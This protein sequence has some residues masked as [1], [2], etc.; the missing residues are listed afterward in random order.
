MYA[1]W[2]ALAFKGQNVCIR[3]DWYWNN[4]DIIIYQVQCQG[5][6]D[7]MDDIVD[8]LFSKEILTSTSGVTAQ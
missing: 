7:N 2:F 8:F 3:G 4:I 6:S 5:S 1:L